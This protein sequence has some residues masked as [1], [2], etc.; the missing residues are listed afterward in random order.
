MTATDSITLVIVQM[1]FTLTIKGK[2]IIKI[3]TIQFQSQDSAKASRASPKHHQE[4]KP[5]QTCP[6]LRRLL[7]LHDDPRQQNHPDGHGGFHWG[8]QENT[9]GDW[10]SSSNYQSRG[11][12]PSPGWSL[13]PCPCPGHLDQLDLGALGTHRA[14]TG[15]LPL[16]LLPAPTGDRGTA[17][18]TYRTHSE[19]WDTALGTHSTHWVLGYCTG[20][21]YGH[22][23]YWDTALDTHT[24][25]WDTAPGAHRN[26]HRV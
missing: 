23:G 5:Q 8:Q 12:E 7:L 2:G 26:T 4:K 10:D 6:H 20:W 22:G 21:L 17:L 13:P 3:C 9:T 18:G 19:H 25:Y 11:M 24:G 14:H 16:D 1:C 15:A